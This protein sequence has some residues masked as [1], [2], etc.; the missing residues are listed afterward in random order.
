MFVVLMTWGIPTFGDQKR[1]TAD[2]PFS[3]IRRDGRIEISLRNQSIATFYFQHP[4]VH[5]SFL[6]HVRSPS[7][8]LV[9]RSYPPDPLIDPTDHADMH[10]GIWIGFAN[11]NGISFWHNSGARV[12]HQR[13]Q[14]L[15]ADKKQAGWTT[16]ERYQD[17]RGK[18]ICSSQSSYRFRQDPV[19]WRVEIEATFHSENEFWFGV[20]EEMGLGFRVATPITVKHGNGRI[21]SASNGRDE[22][23]TWGVHDRWWD[24]SGIVGNRRVGMQLM[25]SPQ[26]GPVWA[27]SRDYGVLVANPFPLDVPGN[28]TKRRTIK[29]GERFKLKYAILVHESKD[30]TF[31]DREAAFRRYLRSGH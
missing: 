9:T 16:H 8:T 22:K 1:D 27:H 17:K 30:S 13:L 2:H 21:D 14:M 3:L 19:G 29:P 20:K 25:T 4:Q 12:I 31:H 6:A 18:L 5:R 7:G 23:G 15:P 10:P 24:Y 28:R 26:N 11:L